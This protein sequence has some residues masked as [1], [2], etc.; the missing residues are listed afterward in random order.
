M[1]RSV[2]GPNRSVDGRLQA[3]S[4]DSTRRLVSPADARLV[5]HTVQRTWSRSAGYHRPM[6]RKK[7][8]TFTVQGDPA[9]ARATTIQALAARRFRVT[10]G[11][12][13]NAVAERGSKVANALAGALAQYMKVVV[14]LQAD[15]VP[16]QTLVRLEKGSS[17]YMGGVIGASRTEKNL[18]TLRDQLA[19][20]FQAAGVLVGVTTG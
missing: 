4:S 12:E 16:G 8:V 3:G 6:A 20:T 15:V 9:A 10:W 1:P 18:L 14:S 5:R 11:D 17:G 19:E 13:W 2:L 7:L